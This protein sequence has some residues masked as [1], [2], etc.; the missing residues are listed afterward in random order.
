[1]AKAIPDPEGLAVYKEVI[2]KTPS[3]PIEG[4]RELT[5]NHLF[6]NL[7]TREGLSIRDRRLI[8]IALLASQ[9]HNDQLRS[10]IRG[11]RGD[12]TSQ[13]LTKKE[14]L[15]LMIHV[16]HYAGWAAGANG[17]IQAESLFE[18]LKSRDD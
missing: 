7:W 16:A 6:A 13:G 8:T 4:F 5:V 2:G 17:T 10:H 12:N 11:A 15:E 18:E 9:G 1:M 14:I 3:K